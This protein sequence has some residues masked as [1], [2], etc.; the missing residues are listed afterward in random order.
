MFKVIKIKT[1][2]LLPLFHTLTTIVGIFFLFIIK[3]VFE[4]ANTV[5]LLVQIILIPLLSTILLFIFYELFGT[6]HTSFLYTFYK[7]KIDKVFLFFVGI[8]SFL[9][10]LI[11]IGIKVS[12]SEFDVFAAFLLLLS[13][14]LLIGTILSI[15]FIIS[16]D[17]SITIAVMVLY[18]SCDIATFGNNKY[19]YHAFYYNLYDPVSFSNVVNILVINLIISLISFKLYKTIVS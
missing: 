16:S 6:K 13:Q 12:Y 18:T 4:E 19:L 7:G 8:F 3:G 9:L 2:N 15:I 1:I 14:L 10:L 5:F 17:I 11:C